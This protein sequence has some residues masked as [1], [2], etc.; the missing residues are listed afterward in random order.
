MLRRPALHLSMR[1]AGG[2]APRQ[3]SMSRQIV[4]LA[5]LLPLAAAAKG[6]PPAWLSTHP[7]NT[8]R[9][10]WIEKNLPDVMPLYETAKKG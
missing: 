4:A 3:H 10:G 2:P 7:S 5:A 6:A 9:I 8:A 1:R